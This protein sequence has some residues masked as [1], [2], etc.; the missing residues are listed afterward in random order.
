MLIDC[1]NEAVIALLKVFDSAG[2]RT[3]E[4]Q[5]SMEM[6]LA[7][8]V[9]VPTIQGFQG[10]LILTYNEFLSKRPSGSHSFAH[11]SEMI[12]ETV[13]WV[14][15]ARIGMGGIAHVPAV[16]HP[17]WGPK[18]G[19]KISLTTP[20]EFRVPVVWKRYLTDSYRRQRAHHFVVD[21][22]KPEDMSGSVDISF[23]GR[24]LFRIRRNG[25]DWA[26][27]VEIAIGDK[28]VAEWLKKVKSA[29]VYNQLC[30]K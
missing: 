16:I 8:E 13:Y 11:G 29:R 19:P 6:R 4:L 18:K 17:P 28:S 15:V 26:T 20:Q 23:F 30:R 12:T 1:N 5:K 9:L 10:E 22:G 24:H 27:K 14:S 21:K 25:L 3:S 2:E 7:E